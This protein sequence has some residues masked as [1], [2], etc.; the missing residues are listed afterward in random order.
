MSNSLEYD[1]TIDCTPELRRSAE[2]NLLSLCAELLAA[3]L[4]N[5]DKEKSLRN[6]NIEEADRAADL[7]SLV[8]N[9]VKEDLSNYH[10][11]MRILKKDGRRYKTL[12]TRL[13]ESYKSRGEAVRDGVSA[14]KQ[15]H[16]YPSGNPN[17][18]A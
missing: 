4:V 18:G 11:F 1:C 2:P 16:V 14:L 6:R 5:E 8:T 15:L 9:K 10:V 3:R 13:E 12:I 17:N 7:V